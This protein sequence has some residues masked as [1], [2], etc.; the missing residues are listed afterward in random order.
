MDS[1]AFASY[2]VKSVVL[3]YRNVSDC[4]GSDNLAGGNGYLSEVMREA[5]KGKGGN[6][7]RRLPHEIPILLL[8]FY[9][10]MISHFTFLFYHNTCEEKN[11]R[12]NEK[13]ECRK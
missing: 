10:L 6:L 2:D 1:G 12:L 13:G 8:I 5:E 11:S 3:S 4:G 9:P 7:M